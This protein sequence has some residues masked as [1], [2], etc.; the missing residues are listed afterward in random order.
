MKTHEAW[1]LGVYSVFRKPNV[2]L[3]R[4]FEVPKAAGVKMHHLV[5]V[6]IGR[7]GEISNVINDEGGPTSPDVRKT[8]KVAE[9]PAAVK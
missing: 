1:G 7:N 2:V 9:Y 6:C 8:P 3:T 4:A 5:T